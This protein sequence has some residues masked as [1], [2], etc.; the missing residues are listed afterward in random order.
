MWAEAAA[1]R[2][3]LSALAVSA[4]LLPASG[5]LAAQTTQRIEGLD[6]TRIEVH[7]G[8]QVEISTAAEM[9]LLVRGPE[10]DLALQPF[11][12]REQVLVLGYNPD[13]RGHDFRRVRYKLA[14]PRLSRLR[15]AGSADVYL[16]SREEAELTLI[17][18][19]SGDLHLHELRVGDL[20]LRVNG[21]GDISAL[22]VQ[23][24]QLDAVVSGSGDIRLDRLEA[25]ELELGIRGSG[26]I[27][28]RSGAGIVDASLAVVGSGDVDL[29]DLDME[30]VGASI[31]GS[32]DVWIGRAQTIDATILGS[33]DVHYAGDPEKNVVVLGSG[34]VH[35]TDR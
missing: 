26:D 23:T 33:G 34:S 13:A 29:R 22:L 25:S 20:E 32:G 5:A 8:V 35:A 31:V 12:A 15:V 7:G 16:E 10:Q 19:G 17:L 28:I 30:H 18:D 24:E 27:K 14:L 21:A 3:W 9:S 6:V 2:R 11:H 1:A 4:L